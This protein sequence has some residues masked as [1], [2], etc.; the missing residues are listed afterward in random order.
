MKIKVKSTIIN[1][2]PISTASDSI[3]WIYDFRTCILSVMILAHSR[4]TVI[5]LLQTPSTSDLH[6][7]SLNLL[8]LRRPPTFSSQL[9]WV[10]PTY[11]QYWLPPRVLHP[12]QSSE[13]HI[14]S[15]TPLVPLY[16][17]KW[18]LL[19]HSEYRTGFD[20]LLDLSEDHQWWTSDPCS[21]PQPP[22]SATPSL[23]SRQ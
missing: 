17:S 4:M 23:S 6:P 3:I 2:R 9:P 21:S 20:N 12:T 8:S 18:R 11:L 16:F 14:K 5:P 10:S 1:L 13:F 15:S 19:V 7:D 22:W